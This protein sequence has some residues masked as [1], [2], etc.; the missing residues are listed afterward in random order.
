[1]LTFSLPLPAH[2][3]LSAADAQFLLLAQLY[4]LERLSAQEA[5]DTLAI[6]LAEFWALLLQWGIPRLKKDEGERFFTPEEYF[7]LA[8]KTE[9]KLEY[10]QG[11]IIPKESS[12]PLPAYL[13]ETML[14]PD[15][16]ETQLLNFPL[17]MASMKHGELAFELASLLKTAL[18]DEPFKVHCQHPCVY[19]MLTGS[20]RIPDVTVAHVP[21]AM[22]EKEQ[23]LNPI[24]IVEVLS[25]STLHK[26]RGEKLAEYQSIESL[27]EYV[28]LHQ[29]EARAEV[30]RREGSN[31]VYENIAGEELTFYLKSINFESPLASI[32]A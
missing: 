17:P 6:P 28:L 18:R 7:A 21:Q 14:A 16:K 9:L 15:F 2:L 27:K 25:P 23:L 13:V 22:N 12:E 1:M 32:Y 19:I 4:Q 24:V 8:G 31:W 29:D 20:F 5:A 10:A 11:K 26:D 3:E 30:Y